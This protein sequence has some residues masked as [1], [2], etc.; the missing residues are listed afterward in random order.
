MT[1]TTTTTTMMKVVVD[2]NE[3]LTSQIFV[4]IFV[5]ST[6]VHFCSCRSEH[7]RREGERCPVRPLLRV[8]L[9]SPL[10]SSSLLF[11]PLLSSSLSSLPTPCW[12][13]VFSACLAF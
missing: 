7:P 8:V 1:M 3:A 6:S 11:S 2:L 5:S 12:S 9:F 4:V 10:L 13:F